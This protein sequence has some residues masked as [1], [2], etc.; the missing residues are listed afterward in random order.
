MMRP[1]TVARILVHLGLA[2]ALASCA[3]TPPP[4]RT[5]TAAKPS[6]PEWPRLDVPGDSPWA[7][8]VPVDQAVALVSHV[9]GPTV[10]VGDTTQS[11]ETI[12][13]HAK[14][15]PAAGWLVVPLP[16]DT[17]A[18]AAEGVKM[19]E[20]RLGGIDGARVFETELV[21]LAAG[22]TKE[23]KLRRVAR[24]SPA[25][26]VGPRSKAATLVLVATNAARAYDLRREA[27]LV[28]AVASQAL[29]PDARLVVAA[30]DQDVALL[31]E[32]AASDLGP[33]AIRALS[34]RGALGA[35]DLG[36]A[37]AW[38]ADRTR[39]ATLERVV[40]V[41]D[42]IATT[43]ETYPR[44]LASFV[45]RLPE[46]TRVDWV[47]PGGA[48]DAAVLSR[49]AAVRP[50]S[51]TSL[52]A[53]IDALVAALTSPAAPPPGRTPELPEWAVASIAATVPPALPDRALGAERLGTLA[54]AARPFDLVGVPKLDPLADLEARK[55]AVRQ[56]EPPAPGS[57]S[58]RPPD[59]RPVAASPPE[60]EPGRLPRETV[61]GIIRRNFGRFRACYIDGLRQKPGI[62][63]RVVVEVE[64]GTD[65]RVALARA[66]SSEIAHPPFVACVVRAFEAIEFPASPGGAV[67]AVYPLAFGPSDEAGTEPPLPS[68]RPDR[69]RG[70]EKLPEL[71]QPPPEPW[72]GK[73]KQVGDAIARGDAAG[74]LGLARGHVSVAPNDAI[75]YVMLSDA[76][77][78]AGRPADAARADGAIADLAPGDE[79]ALRLAALRTLATAGAEDRAEDWLVRSLTLAPRSSDLARAVAE[80]RAL[81]GDLDVALRILDGLL[82]ETPRLSAAVGDRELLR[83]DLSIFGA[84][85]ASRDRTR[86]AELE[87]WLAD[88]GVT[89][90]N[91][92]T[93][94]AALFSHERGVDLDLV[95]EDLSLGRATRSRSNLAT[96][97]ALVASTVGPGPEVF[98]G[99]ARRAYPYGLFAVLA[100]REG[101]FA[102]GIVE[103]VE[104]DGAGK[105]A[106]R[107]HP[108]V[109]QVERGEVKA[110]SLEGSLV[111]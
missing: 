95:V 13:L 49:L 26:T 27:E 12:V 15:G 50:G 58:T 52:H 42:G 17:V 10:V 104:H 35:T 55:L 29:A 40:V 102:A 9:P 108:F 28:R 41:T 25:A 54:N 111:R 85:L 84:A 105:L 80:L 18:V 4:S 77:R 43:G 59:P 79:N 71:P 70:L 83:G 103:V 53:P 31:Y 62:K 3:A 65:G 30:Y 16:A 36:G 109:V 73:V 46:Q 99:D 69:P 81:R 22:E 82:S 89:I 34:E 61:Q 87:R 11:E 14:D 97:G 66:A 106:R 37:L 63:G 110:G 94:R 7:R 24:P 21:A 72:T 98:V 32:G 100:G 6:P 60:P 67:R 74:A 78:A 44:A 5:I 8:F 1:S 2:L 39:T 38:A 91:E 57:T 90:P 75:G 86:R 51:T 33:E 20:R 88:V 45:D 23:L 96:G 64:I 101:P 68:G 47:V 92:G 93:F 19:R 48:R 107:A 56:V 76:L